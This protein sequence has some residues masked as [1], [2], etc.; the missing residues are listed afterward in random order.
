MLGTN[1]STKF[2]PSPLLT[3]ARNLSFW[4]MLL[5]ISLTYIGFSYTSDLTVLFIGLMLIAISAF[6]FALYYIELERLDKE[7]KTLRQ[8]KTSSHS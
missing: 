1:K 8:S 2:K 4:W 6:P 3:S 5:C 7:R